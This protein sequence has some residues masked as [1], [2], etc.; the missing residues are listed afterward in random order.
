MGDNKDNKILGR[1]GEDLAADYLEEK[2]YKIL[3]RNF[4]NR[5]GEIDLICQK[6][7]TAVFTEVK[8]RVGERFGL[9]ENAINRNKIQRLTKNAAAYMSFKIKKKYNNY[10]IDAICIV[11]DEQYKLKRINHYENII[12]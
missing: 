4:Q 12:N 2:G 1:I 3:E 10:R 11:L 8:T 7:N 9:P 5:W 6:D